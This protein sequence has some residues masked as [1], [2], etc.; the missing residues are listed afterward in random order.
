MIF[1]KYIENISYFVLFYDSCSLM[2]VETRM[3]KKEKPFPELK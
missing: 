2:K 3:K 1:Q